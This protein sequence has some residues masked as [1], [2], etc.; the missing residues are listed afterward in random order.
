[1]SLLSIA[2]NNF[3]NNIKT[4]NMF[5]VSLVFSVV[6]LSNF[7]ILMDG[8]A[9]EYL[10]ELRKDDVLQSLMAMTII[11]IIFMFFFIGYSTN[12]FLKKRKKEIGIYTFMGL[13]SVV[14]GKI[15]FIEIIL[16]GLSSCFVGITIGILVSKLFQMIIFKMAEFHIDIPFNVTFKS[17][18]YTVIILMAI[19][20]FMSIKG[21]INIIRSKVIDLLNDSKK[22]EVM[23]RIN[24]FVYVIAIISLGLII[25][26][27]Y[28]VEKEPGNF[29]KT[30]LVVCIGTYGLFGAVMP[31]I[32]NFLI[33]K[34]SILYKGENILTFNNLA[35][36][37]KKNYTTYATIAILTACTITVLGTAVSMKKLYTSSAENDELYSMSFYSPNKIDVKNLGEVVSKIGEK[38]Y[39]VNT[40]VLKAK[41][42]LKNLEEHRGSSYIVLSYEQFLEI[43]KANGN[44]K[45]ISKVNRDMVNGNNVIY[46]QKPTTIMS[47]VTENNITINDIQYRVSEQDIKFKTLGSALNYETIVVNNEEYERIKKNSEIINFYGIKV[48]NEEVLLDNL[49]LQNVTNELDKYMDLKTTKASIGI[50][51]SQKISWLKIVYAIGAFLFLV[52]I[53]AEASIV[54]IKIYSDANEDK[55]K[56]KILLDIGVSREELNKS[57]RKEISLFYIIPLIVGLV[58][59]YFAIKTLGIFM[60][61]NLNN[62]YFLS[63][64]I[65]SIIFGVSCFISNREFKKI[66]KII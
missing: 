30:L 8:N 5:F 31:L 44:E 20:L 49:T 46:I 24:I 18:A 15:Y 6:V 4:Y 32:F 64:S 56:Y 53:L 22:E 62:M 65:C 13:D 11:L 43:L 58:H 38:K 23:P 12:I 27:Y 39:E 26:G 33:N 63:V 59:S 54:Y 66:V 14:I 10:G 60:S 19:F 28:L 1:M 36:R 50:H 41:S 52:F 29:V 45:S 57:I 25:W 61:V 2:Y 42:T 55:D 21:F 17:I 3:K 34:K 16:I 40:S 51:E 35:Y 7:L 47:L 37:I 9:L 48:N